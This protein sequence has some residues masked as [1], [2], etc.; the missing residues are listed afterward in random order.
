MLIK[1]GST[2][3]VPRAQNLLKDVSLHVADNA[4]MSLYPEA[5]PPRRVT[6]RAA[7]GDTVATVARRYRVSVSQVAL[8]NK[9][10]TSARFAPGQSVVVFV[11][12][13]KAVVRGGGKAKKPVIKR[14][15]RKR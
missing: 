2:L 14:K 10:T 13:R 9:V 15:S 11:P 6:H 8:W 4:V 5:Q 12:Q 1:A 7:K 3:L